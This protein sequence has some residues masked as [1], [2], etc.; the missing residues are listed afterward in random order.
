MQQDNNP[1]LRQVILTLREHPNTLKGKFHPE[2]TWHVYIEITEMLSDSGAKRL[3]GAVFFIIMRGL[4][5]KRASFLAHHFPLE[6]SNVD[7]VERANAGLRVRE[8]I[9]ADVQQR[10]G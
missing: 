2:T 7:V 3:D 8:R 5:N 9:C 6:K 4:I 1:N 10:L